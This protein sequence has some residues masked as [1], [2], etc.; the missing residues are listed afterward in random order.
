MG[1]DVSMYA[2][3]VDPP[4]GMVEPTAGE[5]AW[6]VLRQWTSAYPEERYRPPP[7]DLRANYHSKINGEVLVNIARPGVLTEYQFD[8][9]WDTD[10][11]RDG[12]SY[13]VRIDEHGMRHYSVNDEDNLVVNDAIQ[14]DRFYEEHPEWQVARRRRTRRQWEL[15]TNSALS[16]AA[17]AIPAKLAYDRW[18]HDKG[19]TNEAP[20]SAKAQSLDP[21]VHGQMNALEKLRGDPLLPE[22]MKA[23]REL[24]GFYDDNLYTGDIFRPTPD[25]Q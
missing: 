17:L 2:R 15:A 1:A 22:Q 3:D 23:Y 14:Y 13:R 11:Q 18:K 8:T 5:R 10:P 19:T 25:R 21:L 16:L 24:K 9:E 20:H 6:E 4:S 7:I 12:P